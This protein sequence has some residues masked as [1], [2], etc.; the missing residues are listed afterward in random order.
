MKERVTG[1]V[2]SSMAI[3]ENDKR[4]VILTAELGRISAFARG[5]R[6]QRSPLS[7]PT[8]PFTFGTFYIYRGRESYT[9]ESAEAKKYFSELRRDYDN[10]CMGMY[11]CEI[12]D[13]FTR[14][15]NPAREEINLLYIS[16]LALNKDQIP[17]ALIRR[18]F[19]FRF[20][21]V[22]GE[23]PRMF[24]CIK[25]GKKENLSSFLFKEEWMVCKDCQKKGEG[26]ILSSTAVYTLQR[27]LSSPLENLYSFNVSPK[28]LEEIEE[29]VD[30]YFKSH[31]D[32]KFKSLTALI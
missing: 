12:A 5:A 31:T 32:R 18:I 7:A 8:E 2:L 14:E 27:I 6:R 26:I 4:V 16:L 9:L 17:N 13:Y 3:G 15:G 1:I 28:V 11:F 22:E 29:I 21:L 30:K 10:I 20:M 25:C 23:Y 19:E 24:D